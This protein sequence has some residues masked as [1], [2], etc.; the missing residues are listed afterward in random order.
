MAVDT[1]GSTLPNG[2]ANRSIHMR[3][4]V[5][6]MVTNRAYYDTEPTTQRRALPA[7]PH[8]ATNPLTDLQD[9][10][11]SRRTSHVATSCARS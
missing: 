4:G 3:L 2:M 9:D 6:D 11:R 5:I 1:D 10:R 7:R 8:S